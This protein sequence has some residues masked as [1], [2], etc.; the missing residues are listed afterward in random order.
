METIENSE[1]KVLSEF[2]NGSDYS[3]AVE[4]E[5]LKP[6]LLYEV[7]PAGSIIEALLSNTL[8]TVFIRIKLDPEIFPYKKNR[9]LLIAPK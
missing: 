5:S 4:S 2:T 9:R 1:S 6:Q 7:D 3:G 8:K